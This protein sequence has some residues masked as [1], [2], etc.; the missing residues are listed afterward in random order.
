MHH[1]SRTVAPEVVKESVQWYDDLDDR[2]AALASAKHGASEDLDVQAAWVSEA[3]DV[4]T[5]LVEFF[6][7]RSYKNN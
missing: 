3:W 4:N 6:H 1:F 7:D 5:D 2:D